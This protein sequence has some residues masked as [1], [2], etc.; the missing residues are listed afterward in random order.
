MHTFI[1][2]DHNMFVVG[3]NRGHHNCNHS[4]LVGNSDAIYIIWASVLEI[5]VYLVLYII[6]IMRH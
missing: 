2:D 5:V 3:Q 6:H 4:N 1:L